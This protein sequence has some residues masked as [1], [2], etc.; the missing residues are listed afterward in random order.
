MPES[1]FRDP[2]GSC[3]ISN[4]RVFRFVRTDFLQEFESFLKSPS[5]A[6][7]VADARLV[8]TRKVPEAERSSLKCGG[9]NFA[10]NGALFEHDVIVFPSYP[11]EWSPAMLHAAAEL[12]LQI[13]EGLLAD[14]YGIKDATPYNVL[15]RGSAPIFIDVL[16]FERRDPADAIWRAYAQFVR[17]FLLPLLAN[18]LWGVRIAD[19]FLTRRDGFEPEEIYALASRSQRLRPLL[20]NLVSLPVWLG[21]K[22]RKEAVYRDS[23]PIEPEKARF[24]LSSLLRRLR[25]SLTALRADR[26]R[27]SAWS[28]YMEDHSYSD[29]AF[30]AKEQ[31]VR[32]ALEKWKPKNVLDVGANTGHFSRLAAGGGAAVVAID[33]DANCIDALWSEARSRGERILPL[34][35]NLAR[36]TPAV[37]WRNAECASFLKRANGKFDCVLMLAVLHH[38]LVS[39]GIP[40]EEVIELAA[41]LTTD[42]LIIEFVAPEDS[43]FRLIS[44]GR[45][46]LYTELNKESF[47]LAAA[48][49]F[50]IIGSMQLPGAS[51]WLYVFSKKV[52]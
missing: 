13:A 19:A 40:V 50:N 11:A 41:E 25:H 24:I 8:G 21:K 26:K 18:K 15:F 52:D 36:P 27:L 35:V 7:L 3:F 12:T 28:A 22:G 44:R 33:S 9:T 1:S 30:A 45:D 29:Q 5:A 20:L 23:K 46:H 42:K 48:A 14:G 43:M 51:R 38:L 32:E 4:N 10:A 6:K 49:R 39:D 31:F 17:T 47:E 2:A 16:S 34:V 37:G